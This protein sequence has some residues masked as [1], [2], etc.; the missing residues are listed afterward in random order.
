MYGRQVKRFLS[1]LIRFFPDSRALLERE[2]NPYT[3]TISFFAFETTD[4][5]TDLVPNEYVLARFTHGVARKQ[6]YSA[7]K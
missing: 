1:S 5:L 3:T 2:L 7:T 6:T 4:R